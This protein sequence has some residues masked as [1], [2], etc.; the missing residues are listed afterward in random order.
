MIRELNS[1]LR[2]SATME[3][4]IAGPPIV[5]Q[6]QKLNATL[7]PF[8]GLSESIEQIQKAQSRIAAVSATNSKRE[9][10]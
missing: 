6:M 1:V 9:E 7:R 3:A 2:L 8:V 5:R 10:E 4:A